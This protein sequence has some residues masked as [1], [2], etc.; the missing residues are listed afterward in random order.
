M[1][2]LIKV[3][4]RYSKVD[5]SENTTYQKACALS[6]SEAAKISYL[7]TTRPEFSVIGM[8]INPDRDTYDSFQAE[9]VPEGKALVTFEIPCESIHMPDFYKEICNIR[10]NELNIS[11]QRERER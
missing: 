1:H 5:M 4:G 10:N 2:V 6:L 11:V 9:C 8:T 7:I 3:T